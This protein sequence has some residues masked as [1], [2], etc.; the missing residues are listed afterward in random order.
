MDFT[1]INYMVQF[2]SCL[3]NPRVKNYSNSHFKLTLFVNLLCAITMIKH[4]TFLNK[5]CL[6]PPIS[7]L[8]VFQ[9]SA[10]IGHKSI[11]V[12]PLENLLTIENRYTFH[13]IITSSAKISRT[14]S[15]VKSSWLL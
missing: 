6:A 3:F 5:L 11:W 7:Q 9:L 4:E 2:K 15:E 14:F 10:V 13:L 8:Y 1:R 12:C